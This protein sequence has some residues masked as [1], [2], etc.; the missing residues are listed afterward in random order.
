[1]LRTY[2]KGIIIC[3]NDLSVEEVAE[4]LHTKEEAT[5]IYRKDKNVDSVLDSNSTGVILADTWQFYVTNESN[6][7]K[8]PK[9]V[10]NEDNKT[11]LFVGYK[12]KLSKSKRRKL[13]FS[14]LDA[15]VE[16]EEKEEL[17]DNMRETLF[18]MGASA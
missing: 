17:F 13:L 4:Y 14:V 11:I 9:D 1:M 6:A 16:G 5:V 10:C 15:I 12:N 8:L 3:S 18:L 7:N 2:N